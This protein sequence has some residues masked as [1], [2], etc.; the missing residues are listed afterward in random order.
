[1]RLFAI[2]LFLILMTQ[3][4]G[5]PLSGILPVA[6]EARSLTN[7]NWLKER[8]EGRHQDAGAL[9]DGK[10]GYLICLPFPSIHSPGAVNFG[11]RKTRA[12]REL[13]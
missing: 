1:M 9:T 5:L 10:L 12:Y 2:S 4:L 11:Q 8:T 3:G 7:G 6:R 13:P